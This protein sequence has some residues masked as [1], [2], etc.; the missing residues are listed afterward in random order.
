MSEEQDKPDAAKPES[1][2]EGPRCGERLAAAR[3]EQQISVLEV[4]KELHLD[5]PKV[6]ALERNDFD[7]LGAPVF[8]K[9]HL[10]K[11]AQLVGVDEADVFAD[12]YQLTRSERVPPPVV[13]VG[14]SKVRQELS[15]GPW[16]AVIVVIIV[17]AATYWWFAAQSETEVTP[18]PG[19]DEPVVPEQDADSLAAVEQPVVVTSAIVEDEQAPAASQPQPEPVQVPDGETRVSLSFSG[20]CWTEISDATGQR[21]FFDMGRNGR[22]VELAGK[23]PF[24]VLFGNS[25]N[26][27]VRV[28]GNDYPISPSTPGSRTARLTIM[29]Q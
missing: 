17:A 14:R 1:E 28:D 11:Y 29:N 26:V 15:P 5:E 23:A 16:I 19:T 21:L 10:R 27:S 4:A 22:T 2:S 24:A 3:R 7:M 9:G 25:E 13:V 12:Y 6:R 20:D 18:S 8:A